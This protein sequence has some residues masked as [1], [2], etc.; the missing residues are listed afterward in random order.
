MTVGVSPKAKD[1]QD[2]PHK[3]AHHGDDGGEEYYQQ[4]NDWAYQDCHR[5]GR[6]DRD[7]FGQNLGKD[8]DQRGHHHGGNGD[9]F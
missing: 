8:Q 4:L 5:H 7:G 1:T 3:G 6:D 2:Q 9:A